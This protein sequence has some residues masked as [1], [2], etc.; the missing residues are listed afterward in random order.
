MF[1]IGLIV[2]LLVGTTL[3]IILMGALIAGSNADDCHGE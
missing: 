2:G 3:G 1:V